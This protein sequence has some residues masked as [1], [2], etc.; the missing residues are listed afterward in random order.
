VGGTAGFGAEECHGVLRCA[1]PVGVEVPRLRFKEDEARE[2]RPVA[3]AAE[4]AGIQGAAELVGAEGVE[5]AALGERR[6]CRHRVKPPLD[7]GTYGVAGRAAPG[8]GG[9][10]A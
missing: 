7:A 6:R 5:A 9:G 10:L 2:V 4:Q 8:A 1:V 3:A